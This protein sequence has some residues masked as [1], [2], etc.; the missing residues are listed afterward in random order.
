MSAMAHR[1]STRPAQSNEGCA[2]A[3]VGGS[4]SA[5]LTAAAIRRFRDDGYLVVPALCE[6]SERD[7][8][9]DTLLRL[10]VR[11]AGRDEGNQFDMLSPDS[12]A[13][14]QL[15]PQ[16]LKPS[17]Y[18]PSLLQGSYF[19]RVQ[20]IARQLLGADAE[21][22]F[23]HSILKPAGMLAATPWHQDEAHR[24]DPLF[25]SEQISF[26]MP[27]QDVNEHNGCMRYVPGSQLGP[28]L[29]HQAAGKD[30]RLHALE[31][32]TQHFDAARAH[33]QPVP[34][35]WCILHGGR[36]LHSALPNGSDHDRLAYVI[37]FRGLPVACS[38]PLHLDWMDA[39][40]TAAAARHVR[41]LRR[42]GF[43]VVALRWLRAALP[44]GPRSLTSRMRHWL[45]RKL[46]RMR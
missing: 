18:A 3:V 7:R 32:S 36:T 34:A 43:A 6:V 13:Q 10:F 9:H 11:R 44:G 20:S 41:W 35:G 16:I 15:Q 24:R 40:Q 37:S 23:D 22:N 2:G 21:F 30:P 46:A 5:A 8:I 12:D 31:C 33:S 1:R 42:G 29:P 4:G 38:T 45:R 25:H 17:L 27:L 28:L 19:R 26:W 39:Q 14:A